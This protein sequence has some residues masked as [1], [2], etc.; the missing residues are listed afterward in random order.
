MLFEFPDD[1]STSLFI[2][3][4]AYTVCVISETQLL[5][6][7]LGTKKRIAIV[8]D[9]KTIHLTDYFDGFPLA[10]L[11][12]HHILPEFNF[13]TFPFALAYEKDTFDLINLSTMQKDTMIRGAAQNSSEWPATFFMERKNG[14]DMHFCTSRLDEENMYEHAWHILELGSDFFQ[15]L[16]DFGRL[17]PVDSLAEQKV[18]I[19]EIKE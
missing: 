6:P 7:I 1:L 2:K 14:I 11:Q 12:P 8:D 9:W 13:E 16:R 5:F 10:I 3:G 15:T 17:P 19:N 18:L 4:E